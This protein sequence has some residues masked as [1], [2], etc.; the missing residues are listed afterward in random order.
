MCESLPALRSRFLRARLPAS[1]WSRILGR[2]APRDVLAGLLNGSSFNYVMLGSSSDPTAVSSVI[3]TAKSATGETQ[4]QTAANVAE[5]GPSP[6]NAQMPP[7]RF[8][9]PGPFPPGGLIGQRPGV[10]QECAG[11]EFAAGE[12]VQTGTK[13]NDDDKDDDQD[14]ADD[15]PDDQ[16]H[17]LRKWPVSAQAAARLQSAQCR[18]ENSGADIWKCCA[19]NSSR[20]R[21]RLLREA[22]ASADP[23]QQYL[24]IRRPLL[25]VHDPQAIHQRE[26][27][28]KWSRR[29]AS[30]RW[31]GFDVGT[32]AEKVLE[33]RDGFTAA[34]TPLIAQY[35][36]KT[37]K[38]TVR[39]AVLLI[40]KATKSA[41]T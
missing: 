4:N 13:S 38:I 23:T 14:S 16:E 35:A 24:R 6:G 37:P 36:P 28:G 27:A 17:N 39:I 3:L 2:G 12:A 25:G 15:R 21:S 32:N 20:E 22:P 19:D 31:R 1:E 7:T 8:S 41:F 34:N 5:N 40:R 29:G 30:R 18:S 11:R 33:G 10:T 26:S 9:P